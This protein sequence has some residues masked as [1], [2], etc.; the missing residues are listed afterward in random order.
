MHKNE[1]GG[2]VTFNRC[3]KESWNVSER[4]IRQKYSTLSLVFVAVYVR[5]N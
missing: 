4:H 1:A 3:K 5:W 2:L